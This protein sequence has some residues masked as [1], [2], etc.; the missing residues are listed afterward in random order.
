MNFK[1]NVPSADVASADQQNAAGPE[2][3]E[4]QKDEDVAMETEDQDE[5]LHAA[6]IDEMKPEQLDSTKASRKG[7]VFRSF[8]S[9]K[10]W[11][12]KVFLAN[13]PVAVAQARTAESW[14]RKDEMTKRRRR[15]RRSGRNS[16]PAKKTNERRDAQS[17]RFTRSLSCCWKPCR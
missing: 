17:P 13:L 9:V 3:Q 11:R 5:D 7:D 12:Q 15:R 8:R 16:G 1:I 4:D 2:Q 6:E 14:R 10:F